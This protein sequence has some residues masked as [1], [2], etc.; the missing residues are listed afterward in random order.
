MGDRIAALLIL[1]AFLGTTTPIPAQQQEAIPDV[2][3]PEETG[4]TRTDEGESGGAQSS[5]TQ[6]GETS[7]DS[8]GTELPQFDIPGVPLYL[9]VEGRPLT[10]PQDVLFYGR[11][12]PRSHFHGTR[13]VSERRFFEI[14]GDEDAARRSRNHRIVNIGIGTVAI[15]TFFSG[16]ALFATADDVDL[17]A[18]GIST[19][20]TDRGF[21]LAL[22]GGSLV[23]T[24]ILS[25]RR[26]YWAPLE[27]TYQTMRRYNGEEEDS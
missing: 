13:Y 14:A 20:M 27:Y 5:E 10:T 8:N 22:I 23:P 4:E 11:R 3:A 26:Q 9:E 15:L 16:L 25:A 19:G 1:L 12:T 6:G 21:S 2:A 17:A 7:T 24:V 18:A